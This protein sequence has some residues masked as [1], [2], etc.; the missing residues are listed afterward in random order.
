MTTAVA[1][2]CNVSF[3]GAALSMT[4]VFIDLLINRIVNRKTVNS[5]INSDPRSFDCSLEEFSILAAATESLVFHQIWAY[6]VE[7]EVV[8]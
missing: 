6:A 8:A 7:L 4:S 3:I 5:R 2:V 1:M